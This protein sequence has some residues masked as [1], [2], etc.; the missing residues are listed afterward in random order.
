MNQ[1]GATQA[2]LA[3]L[4]LAQPATSSGGSLYSRSSAKRFFAYDFLSDSGS[5]FD[6]ASRQTKRGSRTFESNQDDKPRYQM[7]RI[8]DPQATLSS[9]P[10]VL[11][12][13]VPEME[14]KEFAHFINQCCRAMSMAGKEAAN[15]TESVKELAAEIERRIETSESLRCVNAYSDF[16]CTTNLFSVKI[17]VHPLPSKFGRKLFESFQDIESHPDLQNL[18][19]FDMV[20]LTG[21]FGPNQNISPILA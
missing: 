6:G 1:M 11:K 5:D 9:I 17:D 19:F 4:N 8:N 15:H 18:N 12:T 3:F 10:E 21:I 14:E 20:R 13:K 2:Q 7:N 16:V